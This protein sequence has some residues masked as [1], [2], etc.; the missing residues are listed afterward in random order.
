MTSDLHLVADESCRYRWDLFPW[1]KAEAKAEKAKSLIICGDL[2]DRKDN[3]GA[4]LV[5]KIV[6]TLADMAEVF[7][8][9]TVLAGNHDWLLQGQEYFRFLDK[10]GN[11]RIRFI[12]RPTED[13]DVKGAPTFY[14]PYSKNPA[15]DWEGLDFSHYDFVFMHQ[16]MKGSRASNGEIM[17]GEALPDLSAA[18]KVY[19]GDIHVPQVIGPV[20]YIGSPY[21]VHFGDAFTPRV[22]LLER[23][24]NPVDLFFKTIS[25]VTVK[26]SGLRELE[27]WPLRKGDQVKLRISLTEAERHDWAR[28]RREAK[29]LLREAQVVEAGI[30]LIV[31]KAGNRL[32]APRDRQRMRSPADALYAYV[33]SEELGAEAL[34]IGQ[35]IMEDRL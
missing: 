5:N 35:R 23:G 33:K 1:L 27:R 26:V 6:S 7:Q 10:V 13:P 32:D 8:D 21:H 34:D 4:D 16:T 3:H 12:T 30:E 18:G 29:A 19:S 15:K 17:E 22:L 31:D 11:G 28:I 14:L 25:R 9:V 24:G 2:T 20:E